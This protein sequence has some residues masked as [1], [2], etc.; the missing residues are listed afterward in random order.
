MMDIF[1]MVNLLIA[2]IADLFAT[3]VSFWDI[4]GPFL[5]V[6]SPSKT[7]PG[8][9][10]L[11]ITWQEN[12]LQILIISFPWSLTIRSQLSRYIPLEHWVWVDK[13]FV[14]NSHTFHLNHLHRTPDAYYQSGQIRLQHC[15]SPLDRRMGS[16]EEQCRLRKLCSH[17]WIGWKY[18]REHSYWRL[19]QIV[20]NSPW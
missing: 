12:V 15:K 17:F 16:P 3:I 4:R 11:F 18:D 5:K 2:D 19:L 13:S 7:F 20:T 8:K 9:F 6:K 1:C 10:R 14:A